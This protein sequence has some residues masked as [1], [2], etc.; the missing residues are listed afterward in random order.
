MSGKVI[1]VTGGYSGFGKETVKVRRYD[2]RLRYNL[3]LAMS[4]GPAQS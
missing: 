2:L 1:I 3:H 4:L